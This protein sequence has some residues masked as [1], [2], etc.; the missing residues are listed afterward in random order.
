MHNR[1][2]NGVAVLALCAAPLRA[3]Q[4]T[5][6]D[7][8]LARLTREALQANAGLAAASSRAQALGA[9]IR[10]AG[11]LADPTVMVGVMDLTLP[12]FAFRQSDFTEIDVQAEQVFPWPGTLSARARGASGFAQAAQADLH[13]RERDV[14]MRV[15]AIYYQLRYTVTARASLVHQ[16]DVLSGTVDAA[17][18]RYTIGEAPQSDALQARTVLARLDA[19]AA[20]L[21][22][23][24]GSLRSQLRRLR[25]VRG[26]DSIDIPPIAPHE[27]MMMAHMMSEPWTTLPAPA[28]DDPRLVASRARATAATDLVEAERLGGRPE[29]T[30]TARYGARPLGADFASAFVGVRIPLWSGRKQSA[31]VNAATADATAARADVADAEAALR[32]EIEEMT[33]VARAGHERLVILVDRVMPSATAAVEAALRSYRLGQASISAVLSAQDAEYRTRLEM[34]LAATDHLNHL[35]MLGQ[36]ARQGAAQ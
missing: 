23:D 18:T 25:N 11:T 16:R 19:D 7:S 30:V 24:E 33:A 4:M 27:S 9:R 36:L 6:T 34:A 32:S 29:F 8:L 3:Q 28:P 20:T 31:L 5:M 12:Q 2:W 35:V 22:G 13:D 21:A 10:P 15:A 17:L 14:T 1:F 26:A